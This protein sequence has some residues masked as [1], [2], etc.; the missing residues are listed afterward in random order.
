MSRQ[1]F[2]LR[3]RVNRV[4]LRIF[5]GIG[6]FILIGAPLL[7]V[8]LQIRQRAYREILD[9]EATVA[10]ERGDLV[11]A[12]RLT[13]RLLEV[14]PGNFDAA[15]RYARIQ[16]RKADTSDVMNK[17]RELLKNVLDQ[18]PG[19]RVERRLVVDLAMK[20]EDYSDAIFHL[21]YLVESASDDQLA[22]LEDL[23]GQCHAKS[24]KI[25]SAAEYFEKS[26]TRAPDRIETYRRFAD[27]LRDEGKSPRNADELMDRMVLANPKSSKAYLERGRYRTAHEL[28]GAKEDIFN[29]RKITPENPEILIAATEL[30]SQD[31]QKADV[32]QLRNEIESAFKT[33][34]ADS[35]LAFALARLQFRDNQIEE[36]I[37]TLRSGLEKS[38]DA[39]NLRWMLADALLD[40]KRQDEALPQIDGLRKSKVRS[41]L[42]DYLDAR[43]LFSDEKW[44][45]AARTF[46][47]IRPSLREIDGFQTQINRLDHFIAICAEKLN[48]TEAKEIALRRII[49]QSPRS[50]S[51]QVAL[52]GLLATSNRIPEALLV[53]RKL[54]VDS[55]RYHLEIAQLLLSQTMALSP[56]DRRWSEIEKE[57][58]AA[59]IALPDSPLVPV[60][61]AAVQIG[62]GQ[63]VA[64]HAIL[65]EAKGKFGDRVEVW[66]ALT[67]LARAEGKE[68]EVLPLLE[69][70]RKRV[71]DRSELP[72]IQI[73]YWMRKGGDDAPE[74]LRKLE[75]GID[76]RP[77]SEQQPLLAT[78]AIAYLRIGAEAES[79]R[80]WDKLGERFPKELSFRL[81]LFDRSIRKGDPDAMKRAL[82][83]VRELEGSNGPWGDHCEIRLDFFKSQHGDA[84][85]LERARNLA[86]SVS[87]NRP[88]WRPVVLLLAQSMDLT[89]NRSKAIESYLRTITLG[90]NDPGVIR[91]TVELLYTNRR[92]AE[93]AG[94]LDK[95]QAQVL[96]QGDLRR[97]SEDLLVKTQ[98]PAP[99]LASARKAV[100]DGSKDYKDY[101]WLGRLLW[102]S[103]NRDEVEPIFRKAIA[104]NGAVFE[105]WQLLVE[106]LIANGQR[107]NAESVLNE[108]A[109]TLPTE[110]FLLEYAA[111]EERIG[112]TKAA[113]DLYVRALGAKPDDPSTLRQV[114]E[115]EFRAGRSKATEPRLKAMISSKQTSAEDL[116]WARVNFAI[117]VSEGGDNRRCD[118]ALTQL[119]AAEKAQVEASS[120]DVRQINRARGIVLSRQP[121][122][123]RRKEAIQLLEGAVRQPDADISDRLL[124]AVLYEEEG[125]WDAAKVTLA[126]LLP[127]KG[128]DIDF[129]AAYSRGLLRRGDAKG[130]RPL[131]ERM[132]KLDA[133]SIRTAEIEA[134]VLR[135]E[136]KP[137]EAGLILETFAKGKDDRTGRICAALLEEIGVLKNAESL[138]RALATQSESVDNALS[139][140]MFLARRNRA[141]DALSVCETQRTKNNPDLVAST[142]L[143]VLATADVTDDQCERVAKWLEEV[144]AK[145]PQAAEPLLRLGTIRDIQ[146]RYKE[147]EAFYRRAI[148]ADPSKCAIPLNNLAWILTFQSGREAEAL[149][150]IDRA[151]AIAGPLPDLLD[152]RAV[153]NLSLNQSDKAI[154]DMEKAVAASPTASRLF[155]LSEAYQVTNELRLARENFDKS[156]VAG[157]SA[158]KLHALERPIY[159]KLSIEFA[160]K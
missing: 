2:E 76:A 19:R 42:T 73:Q 45:A 155:H 128:G 107:E 29:A 156:V 111:C 20:L 116:A 101:V 126:S 153:I 22:E 82:D 63:I 141:D 38:P 66:T 149:G 112:H 109:N 24:K 27:F 104:L 89:G 133:G 91:R 52:A 49:E 92:F 28:T 154:L 12:E 134:R 37:A 17:A 148:E 125:N 150:L 118:E 142:C 122:R 86:T 39:V 36:A 64:G 135:V 120:E 139:L 67:E 51:D 95:I 88:N 56:K 79:D 159:Q 10:E 114:A 117:L 81:A 97:L 46:E 129:L 115:H 60:M 21:M 96:A 145:T 69:E 9:K 140:A 44:S 34:P 85:A 13:V 137:D 77:L 98:R 6:L 124:L 119:D 23:I 106:F 47:K 72:Q 94:L 151:I 40:L 146:G 61:A 100:A 53:Y 110:K 147:A 143:Y 80:V 70:A 144:I 7:T 57:L 1:E 35:E 108:A 8:F 99:A 113:D 127:S 90:E 50:V 30:V 33:H 31:W 160:P 16:G 55:P 102:S 32:T 131:L 62:Q 105:P 54:A 15:A 26:I 138:Y 65:E 43:V 157:L 93:A 41:T 25:D 158:K 121:G 152:T 4:R 130:A 74:A 103:G 132:K 59:A 123:P 11:E 5:L 14:R 3:A 75:T 68:S 71:G 136:E 84:G 48:D 83:G 58:K 87:A 78:L 18:V